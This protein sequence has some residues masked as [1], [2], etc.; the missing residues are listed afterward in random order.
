MTHGEETAS[1]KSID[2]TKV[3]RRLLKIAKDKRIITETSDS[4]RM[5]MWS[6]R[7]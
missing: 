4:Q 7:M 2:T 5:R 3:R 1:G 6:S